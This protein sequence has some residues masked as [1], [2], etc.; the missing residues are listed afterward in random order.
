MYGVEVSMLAGRRLVLPNGGGERRSRG[1]MLM[2]VGSRIVDLISKGIRLAMMLVNIV[3]V[4]V[5]IRSKG[6]GGL[7]NG[8]AD[9]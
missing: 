3:I 4:C 7:R 6:V 5:Y 8:G 1:G 9:D 2:F